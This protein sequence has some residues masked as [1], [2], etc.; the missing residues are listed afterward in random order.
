M[1]GAL[2]AAALLLL[3]SLGALVL[4]ARW[5]WI[6]A[7]F[8]V[9][10]LAGGWLIAT[11]QRPRERP[12]DEAL[13]ARVRLALIRLCVVADMPTPE[14]RVWRGL[15]PLSWTTQLPFGRPRVHV[16]EAMVQRIDDRGMEAVLAHEMAHIANGDA[17]IMTVLAAPA[18]AMLTAF[19]SLRHVADM[20]W[21]LFLFL[22]TGVAVLPALALMGLARLASRHRE[23]AADR[24]AAVLT[25]SPAGLA[26]VLVALS[27]GLA[28]VPVTDLREVARADV[29]HLLPM[30]EATGLA[31]LWATHP[32]LRRRLAALQEMERHMSAH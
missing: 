5:L 7:A 15:P 20:G 22:V 32:P 27:E 8:Y 13:E 3:A 28:R 9:V 16:S 23:L 12:G 21:G 24:G 17:R 2:A 6:A 29:F 25:G 31:R 10:A 1:V 30:R 14:I 11:L 4:L 26:A 18:L 19:W